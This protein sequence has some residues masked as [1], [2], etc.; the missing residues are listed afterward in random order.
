[1]RVSL[2]AFDLSHNCL[3]RTHV[4]AM[5]LDRHHEVEIVGPKFDSSVWEPLA[6]KYDYRGVET[7]SY[8]WEFPRKADDI[9][10]NVTGDV[11]YARKPRATSFGLG[12]VHRRRTGTPLLLDIEDWEVGLFL[13]YRSRLR[14]ATTGIPKLIDLNSYYPTL[15]SESLTGRADGVTVSNRFLQQKFGGELLPHVRDTDV[16]DPTRFDSAE[17]RRETGLPEDD[18]LIMFTGT[19]RPHKG[20]LEL[21]KAVRSLDREDVTVVVVGADDSEYVQ[22]IERIGGDAVVTVPPQPFDEVPRWVAM[23]DIVAAPQRQTAGL[24][25]QIPAKV[26]DAM[27][28]GKPVVATAISDLPDMLDGCGVLV[29]EPTPEALA[30]ALRSLVDDPGKRAAYGRVARSRAVEKYSVEAQVPMLDA[31]LESAVETRSH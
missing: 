24:H 29:D 31:L 28:L 17:L 12:L 25:G 2:L 10:E 5:V 30:E 13:T 16:F 19:P 8:V 11:V 26:F 3:V 22:D 18:V 4:L 23:A 15:L 6:D 14:A 1:M 9:L 7:S 20:V 21:V 27:A